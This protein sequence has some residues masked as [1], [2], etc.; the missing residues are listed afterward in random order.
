LSQ[1]EGRIS[2]GKPRLHEPEGNG[3]LSGKGETLMTGKKNS[4]KRGL[5][6]QQRRKKG[7][8]GPIHRRN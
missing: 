3:H 1:W 6:E 8:G 4:G 5:E 2:G 7:I